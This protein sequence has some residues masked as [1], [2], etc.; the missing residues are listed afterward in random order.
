MLCSRRAGGPCR[1]PVYLLVTLVLALAGAGLLPGPARAQAPRTITLAAPVAGA[2]ISSPVELRGRVTV[3]P[4]ENNLVGTVVDATGRTL[5]SGPVTVTPDDPSVLGGPGSFSGRVSFT[6]AGGGAGRVAVA[7]VS[8]ADGSVLA[9]A[10]VD[11]VLPGGPPGA[12]RAGRPAGPTQGRVAGATYINRSAGYTHRL[13][14][15]WVNHGYKWYEYWGTNA[16][17]A[18]PGAAYVA[19]WVYVPMDPAKP[20]AT[21]VTVAVYP[22]AVWQAMAAEGGPPAGEP[23]AATDRW[24][25]AWSGRQDAPY[26]DGS[27]DDQQ[28]AALYADAHVIVDTFRLLPSAGRPRAVPP[29]ATP[30]P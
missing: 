10:S 8:Q 2:T 13:P 28:A 20:E 17:Q 30:S 27:A 24:V 19:E 12:A 1:R 4:F 25:Y 9:S 22:A 26:G 14:P 23:L 29:T 6:G 7:D 11:V 5:G 15:S 16:D 21:L 18:R 3:A